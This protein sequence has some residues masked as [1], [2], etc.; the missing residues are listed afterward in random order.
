MPKRV[1]RKLNPLSIQK[2]DVVME[3]RI[4]SPELVRLTR[5]KY[6][7]NDYTFVDLRLFR[8]G[9]DEDG[10][11]VFHPT[12]KGIQMKEEDFLSL[13]APYLDVA[14]RA[15]SGRNVH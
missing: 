9:Y 13:V 15:I 3:M 12:P 4:R 2:I 10:N 7:G 11:E 5:V 6:E 8:R 1:R 14:G